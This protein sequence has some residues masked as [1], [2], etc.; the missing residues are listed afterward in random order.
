MSAQEN[1]SSGANSQAKFR[2]ISVLKACA[3]VIKP[4][5]LGLSNLISKCAALTLTRLPDS[6]ST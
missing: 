4:A 2:S 6:N 5:G 3:E 1:S